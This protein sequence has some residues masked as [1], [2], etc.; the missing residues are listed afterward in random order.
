MFARERVCFS[1][2]IVS[3]SSMWVSLV[4]VFCVMLCSD[5]EGL[6]GVLEAFS[7]GFFDDAK[8]SEFHDDYDCCLSF[9]LGF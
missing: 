2:V 9:Y 5:S 8:L 1:L 3:W 4:S 7:V 6:E